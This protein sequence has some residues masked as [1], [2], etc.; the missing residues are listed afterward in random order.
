MVRLRLLTP[1]SKII[2]D[3]GDNR[4]NSEDSRYWDLFQQI[5]SLENLFSFG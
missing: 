3:D 2:L 1:L 5:T 4:H